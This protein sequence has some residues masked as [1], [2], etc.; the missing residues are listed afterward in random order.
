MARNGTSGDHLTLQAAADVFNIQIVVY[1]TL[2]TLATQTISPMNGCPIATFYVGHFAEGAEEHYVCLADEFRDETSSDP[3]D[4]EYNCLSPVQNE[5]SE[6]DGT[7]GIDMPEDQPNSNTDRH[8]ADRHNLWE[9]KP[10]C[11]KIKSKIWITS[12]D[13]NSRKSITQVSLTIEIQ[14]MVL[15]SILMFWRTF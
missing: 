1:S 10:D 8:A 12:V 9:K 4:T 13:M 14:T 3:S 11:M 7:S 2:G 6:L 5:Q 15:T